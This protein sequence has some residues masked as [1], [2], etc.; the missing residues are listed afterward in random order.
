[1][2]QNQTHCAEIAHGVSAKNRIKIV[3]KAEKL[4]IKVINKDARLHKAEAK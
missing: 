4:S 3:E 1:M 2:M